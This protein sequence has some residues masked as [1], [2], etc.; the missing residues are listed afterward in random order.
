M[1]EQKYFAIHSWKDVAAHCHLCTLAGCVCRCT[2]VISFP[3]FLQ[4]NKLEE[5]EHQNRD[6]NTWA[7]F[8]QIFAVLT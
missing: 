8:H 4:K 5:V 2:T 3:Q 1:I 6:R 7:Q